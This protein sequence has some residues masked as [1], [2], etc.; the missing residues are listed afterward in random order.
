MTGWF[1]RLLG[2]THTCAPHVDRHRDSAAAIERAADEHTA[3]AL[4]ARAALA[5]LLERQAAA[6]EKDDAAARARLAQGFS[7]GGNG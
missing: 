7:V 6:A 1:R 4:D 3:A 5:A 2:R